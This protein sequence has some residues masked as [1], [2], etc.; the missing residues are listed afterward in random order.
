MGEMHRLTL[1]IHRYNP[2]Q[3]RSWIQE[4]TVDV[5]GILRFTDVLRKIN[6]EQDPGLA[7]ISS[8]EH[9]QCGSCGAVVNGKPLL[10]CELLVQNAVQ[11]FKTTTFNLKPLS[12]APVLR[13]LI[14]DLPQAYERVHA[15]KPYV[16][17][18]AEIPPEGDELRISPEIMEQYVEATRCINCFCCAEACI[19]SHRHFLG[20]NAMM[21][22]I[23]RLFDPKEKAKK[24][25]LEILYGANGVA[26]CH[27]SEACSYVCP[28]QIDVAH[29]IA[30][31]KEER[32][33]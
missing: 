2:E 14:V 28:K 30:L 21:I 11:Q 17:E 26:R 15:V 18:P 4:Y 22:N 1:Q 13:D 6:Q 31:G 19:S 16:I 20:P 12:I 9:G 10:M 8:C 33:S 25:R 7:W 23:V 29:F 5:G 32:F 3:K 24:E 27:T